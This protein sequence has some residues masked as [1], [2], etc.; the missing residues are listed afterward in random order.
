MAKDTNEI[1][2]KKLDEL[3]QLTKHGIAIQLFISGATMGE[4]SKNLHIS[5]VTLVPMLKGIKKEK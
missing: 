3:I 1:I 5:T 2:E 4:I